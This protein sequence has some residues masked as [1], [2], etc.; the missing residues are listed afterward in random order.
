MCGCVHKRIA[1][2]IKIEEKEEKESAA[3]DE[4]VFEIT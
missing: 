1:W 3:K 4:I 2:E